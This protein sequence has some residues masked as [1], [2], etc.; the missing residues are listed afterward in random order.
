MTEAQVAEWGL[1]LGLP[2]LMIFMCF[3]IWDLAKESRAG[4]FGTFVLFLGL[5]L[6]M[7]GFI[8]KQ[9]IAFFFNHS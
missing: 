4:R 6:G 8:A 7:L 9:V 1:N 3:I 2:A 5:G